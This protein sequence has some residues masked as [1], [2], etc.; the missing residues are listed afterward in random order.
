MKL[1]TIFLGLFIIQFVIFAF[2]LL[3]YLGFSEMDSLERQ[4]YNIMTNIKFLITV[5]LYV[6]WRVTPENK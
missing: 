3:G 4:T 6:A 5:A 1:K 2:W